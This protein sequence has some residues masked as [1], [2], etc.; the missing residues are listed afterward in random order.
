MRKQI[1]IAIAGS[2]GKEFREVALMP[3][4]RVSDVLNQ[5][6]LHG[7]QLNRAEG[8]M[9]GKDDNLYDAVADGQ[10]LFAV[11]GDVVAGDYPR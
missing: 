1:T 6:G 5:L 3:N 2:E 10:K 9:F 4:T 7:Y 8:G 11:L